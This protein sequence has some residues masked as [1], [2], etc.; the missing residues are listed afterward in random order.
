[1]KKYV[2][3]IQVT[4]FSWSM[5]YACL[6]HTKKMWVNAASMEHRGVNLTVN[7]DTFLGYCR[8]PVHKIHWTTRYRHSQSHV[9]WKSA[10]SALPRWHNV[11]DNSWMIVK[12]EWQVENYKV[13]FFNMLLYLFS[14]DEQELSCLSPN[15]QY[16][17]VAIDDLNFFCTPKVVS[18]LYRHRYI[19]ILNYAVRSKTLENLI[20]N[21]WKP[22]YS[23]KSSWWSDY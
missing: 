17:L 13:I 18:K 20:W 22:N 15:S 6:S 14:Q 3:C 1:M 16:V 2:L 21:S 12:I 5:Q 11:M 9:C 7:V 4:Q 8:Q 23:T 10:S 19:I